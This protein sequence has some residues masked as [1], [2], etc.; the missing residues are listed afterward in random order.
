MEATPSIALIKGVFVHC[1]W[2]LILFQ[3]MLLGWL[4]CRT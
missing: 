4:Y 1:V 3:K 2:R